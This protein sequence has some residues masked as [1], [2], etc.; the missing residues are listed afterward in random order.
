MQEQCL[1]LEQYAVIKIIHIFL[2]QEK[3]KNNAFYFCYVL[4]L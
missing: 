1:L 2:V 4:Y 3:I